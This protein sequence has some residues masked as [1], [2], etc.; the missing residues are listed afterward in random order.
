MQ[1]ATAELR[2]VGAPERHFAKGNPD[3]PEKELVDSLVESLTASG[4][5]HVYREVKGR[6]WA[7]HPTD[8][9]KE[10]RVDLILSPRPRLMKAGWTHGMVGIECKRGGERLAPVVAQ[11]ADY[12]RSL[13]A[14]R[15]ES[16]AGKP[17][18]A[19]TW[20][21]YVFVYEFDLPGG[22]LESM[23]ASAGIGV[24]HWAID[25]PQRSRVLRF[26]VGGCSLLR[27]HENGD[28]TVGDN[29]APGRKVGSR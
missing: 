13:F 5:F 10:V 20:L 6:L 28:I 3:Q 23:M 21:P 1:P 19:W 24:L 4:A 18:R 29:P 25:G 16:E 2:I 14:L 8:Q 15:D 27:I 11:A 7:Q 26:K 12:R 9:A 17:L 22:D